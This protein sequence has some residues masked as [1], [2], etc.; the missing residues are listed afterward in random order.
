MAKKVK[1]AA[2]AA[3]KAAP[4]AKEAK[5]VLTPEEKA[6]K[7]AARKEAL[8]NRPAGQRPNSKQ[9]DIIEL[10]NGGKVLNFAAPVRKHGSLITSV[11]LN[12]NG[13]VVSTSVVMIEGVSAKSKKGHGYLVDKMPG[14]GK[15]SKAEEAEDEDANEA[16]EDEAEEEDED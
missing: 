6:A 14:A 16:D 3:A 5:K 10:E 4:A 12:A 13:E 2:K 7:K 11:A 9:I 1:E 15:A 8:K